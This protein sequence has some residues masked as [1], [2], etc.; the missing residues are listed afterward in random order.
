MDYVTLKLIHQGC[1]AASATGFLIRAYSSLAKAHAPRPGRFARIAPHLVDTVLL[2]TAL[3]M[4]WHLGAA[5]L[6]F[7]WL[8]T[9][10]VLLLAY[11]A[12][13]SIALSPRRSRRTRT[14]AFFLACMVFLG[15]VASAI[16]K[17]PLGL[18]VFSAIAPPISHEGPIVA[19][20]VPNCM[21]KFPTNA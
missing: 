5:A 2:G 19:E 8:Q 21:E 3:A 16:S 1:A 15:I 6:K 20:F 14:R 10:L 9:K 11:I 18:V 17:H 13:G 7:P 4:T 12:L